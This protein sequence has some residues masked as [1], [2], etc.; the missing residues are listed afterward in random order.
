MGRLS[1][2]CRAPQNGDTPLHYAAIGGHSAVV[3]QLLAAGAAV[4]KKNK[5]KGGGGG[6]R[7]GLG[8]RTQL[9]VS[10]WFSCFVLLGIWVSLPGSVRELITLIRCKR[11]NVTDSP[12]NHLNELIRSH[13]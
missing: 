10:S 6:V 2:R 5:V 8:G 11:G 4:D 7:G 13:M 1:E 3:E 9:C 12:A